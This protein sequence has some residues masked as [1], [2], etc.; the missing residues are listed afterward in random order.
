[1][2]IE[3]VLKE[4][5]W[6]TWSVFTEWLIEA[7]ADPDEARKILEKMDHLWQGKDMAT[8]YFLKFEQLASSTGI[9]TG[10]MVYVVMM[11][12][13]GLNTS[14]VDNNY[15]STSCLMNYKEYKYKAI[16]TDE[17]W[18]RREDLKRGT[19]PNPQWLTIPMKK[20]NPHAMEIDRRKGPDQQKCFWCQKE[21]HLVWDWPE[22]DAAWTIT[23]EEKKDFPKPST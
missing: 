8:E 17:L 21:G 23:E 1:V 5:S 18:R 6:G 16:V 19:T 11:V 12:E 22:K 13:K 4:E 2:F 10:D 9:S 3:R 7:F 14:V 20:V 15:C